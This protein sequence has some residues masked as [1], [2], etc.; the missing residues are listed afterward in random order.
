MP[1]RRKR[2]RKNPQVEEYVRRLPPQNRRIVEALRRFIIDEFP[3][4]KEEFKWH[5]AFYSPAC[6]INI[7]DNVV[8]VGFPWGASLT[9]PGKLLTGKGKLIRHLQVDQPSKIRLK[10]LKEFIKE[11]LEL[12]DGWRSKN[13]RA[14]QAL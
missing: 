13:K 9:D 5:C 2:T 3:E 11:S 8:Y 1:Q 12:Y 10:E 6:Y 14:T 7:S 4:L